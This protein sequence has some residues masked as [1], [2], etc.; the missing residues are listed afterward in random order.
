MIDSVSQEKT[1]I[2]SLA[3]GQSV[4]EAVETYE[5]DSEVI[6]AQPNYIYSLQEEYDT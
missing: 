4:E 3:D 1:A 2:V 5:N 6:S